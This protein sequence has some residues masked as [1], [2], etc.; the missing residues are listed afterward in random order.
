MLNVSLLLALFI[1]AA[2]V[3]MF[4]EYFM[5]CASPKSKK[6]KR[7]NDRNRGIVGHYRDAS[8]REVVIDVD[9]NFSS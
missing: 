4:D 5:I 7:D 2:P 1:T 6:V 9:T 8:G 3:K